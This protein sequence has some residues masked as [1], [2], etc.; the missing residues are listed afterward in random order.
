L[1]RRTGVNGWYVPQAHPARAAL[2]ERL[3]LFRKYYL[4][5]PFRRRKQLRKARGQ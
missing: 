1:L 3:Q 4:G 5:T 2:G